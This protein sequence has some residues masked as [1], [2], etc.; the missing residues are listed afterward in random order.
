MF[1][2][3]SQSSVQLLSYIQLFATPWTVA[4]QACLSI[5]NFQS[6]LKLMPIES[7]MPSNH[8]SSSSPPAFSLSQHQELVKLVSSLHEVS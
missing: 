3:L 7:V 8:L 5:T 1:I 2:Q 4:L 6:L